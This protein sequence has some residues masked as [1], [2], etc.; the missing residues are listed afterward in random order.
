MTQV[1]FPFLYSEH[2]AGLWYADLVVLGRN[3]FLVGVTAMSLRALWISTRPDRPA[4]DE[5]PAPAAP[6]VTYAGT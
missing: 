1:D 2:F 6:E 4:D 5:Q 3:A